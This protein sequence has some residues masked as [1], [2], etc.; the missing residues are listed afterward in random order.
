MILRCHACGQK[1]SIADEKL[2]GRTAKIRCRACGEYVIVSLPKE[3]SYDAGYGAVDY[4]H[5]E[6]GHP[7]PYGEPSEGYPYAD[8]GR[9]G[10]AGYDYGD[11]EYGQGDGAY[12]YA[13]YGREDEAAT[14]EGYGAGYGG[15]GD[16]RVHA[17][18]GYDPER[19]R[20]SRSAAVIRRNDARAHRDMFAA[21][22][23][24]H[25]AYGDSYD[26]EEAR[27]R[28]EEAPYPGGLGGTGARNENSV[29]FS[30]SALTDMQRKKEA[31]SAAPAQP[32]ALAVSSDSGIIDLNALMGAANRG[33]AKL[34]S[35]PVVSAFSSEPPPAVASDVAP[36][37]PPRRRRGIVVAAVAAGVALVA[38]F[39]LGNVLFPFGDESEVEERAAASAPMP[40]STPESARADTRPAPPVTLPRADETARTEDAADADERDEAP[41]RAR[42]QT[43]HRRHGASSATKAKGSKPAGN[44]PCHCGGNLQCAMRCAT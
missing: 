21:T 27:C 15:P 32:R 37:P 28:R 9:P 5:R 14:A 1:Y 13:A 30:I 19:E 29:L 3:T 12:G 16:D 20:P 25:D 23:E 31:A 10:E 42:A 11:A 7:D 22:E 6:H 40:E 18:H 43:R 44:D 36:A 8:Y 2:R 41:K 39:S 34:V 26:A 17:H 38:V 4:G 35:G 24:S 33:P